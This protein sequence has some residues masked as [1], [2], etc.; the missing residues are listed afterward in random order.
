MAERHAEWSGEERRTRARQHIALVGF[1]GAGKTSVGKRLATE[2]GYRFVD[3]DEVIANAAGQSVTE[4]FRDH[5]EVGF[6]A[7]ERAA[8]R[9]V[10]A[11]GDPCVIATGGGTFADPSMREWIQKA[12][13]TIYLRAST[14]VLM[15]R[16]GHGA[17][18]A[19]RPLLAGPDPRAT[20]SR[21]LTERASSYEQC[22]HTV[23]T[24]DTE[25]GDVV[26]QIVRV[27]HLEPGNPAM[28]RQDGRASAR[29]TTVLPTVEVQTASAHYKVE[30]RREA[31]AWIAAAVADAAKGAHVA[32]LSDTTVAPLHAERLVS[33][34]RARGKSVSVHTF[35][36]GESSKSLATCETLYEELLAAGLG[37]RDLI[38]ALGGGV[39][40]D[41][42]GFVASTILRG[43][44]Y[45]QV[46]TTT[47]AAVDSS[48]GGKTGVNTRAG[49][50]LVG[51]FCQ[52]RAVLVAVQHLA[53]QSKRAH[54]A[55]L[56]E[57]VKMAACLDADLFGEIMRRADALLAFEPQALLAVISRAVQ[58]KAAVVAR[59]EREA[60]ERIVLNY[61]HTVGH[62]IEVGE[63]YRLLHG[64]AVALGMIAECEWAEQE[65]LSADVAAPLLGA[66][67]A[68]GVPSAWK[69]SRVDLVAMGLD[70]K[71]AGSSVRVP[72]IPHLGSFELRSV[73][74][75]T[76][77]EF[78]KRRTAA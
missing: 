75:A 61:G 12:A 65:G 7:R 63:S 39:V 20:I 27:L 38:V 26:E 2:C 58:L 30:L 25:V 11:S 59:D 43:V 41:V 47:L 29:R 8:L 67:A 23:S 34:L 60:G 31:G 18:R 40:G 72:V 56:V 1:M 22:E 73:P 15:T 14:E 49:K 6:R 53:T 68:L 36:P 16:I 37:R 4:I 19:Q 33:D 44:D 46:P 5:G 13:R 42:A 28:R 48:V 45:V 3:L 35:A 74:I 17:E 32:V 70:K 10:L 51:T 57:A 52:P 77:V 66:L 9:D 21:L 71:R 55:G 64:E 50:N 69:Q 78:V 24:D 62:A 76:L 54:A